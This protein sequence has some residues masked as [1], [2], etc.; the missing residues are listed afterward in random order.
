[1]SKYT[2]LKSFPTGTECRIVANIGSALRHEGLEAEVLEGES[3]M[4][5]LSI[6]ASIAFT[7]VLIIHSPLAYAVLYVSWAR[8]LGKRVVGLVWDHYPVT[9]SGQ[10]YDKSLRRRAADWLENLSI[11][12]CTHLIVP[13]RDFQSAARLER[14][15]FVPFWL[16]VQRPDDVF[17]TGSLTTDARIRI[18][19]AGQVNETR[20]LSEAFAELELQFGDRFELVIASADPVPPELQGM[21]NVHHLGFLTAEALK[22][23]LIRCHAGLVALSPRFDGPGLPSKTWEYLGAG[24]RCVFVGK[25]LPHYSEALVS[26]G[27]GVVLSPET[28]GKIDAQDLVANRDDESQKAR[29]FSAYFELDGARLAAHLK[30][31]LNP[32]RDK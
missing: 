24:L 22:A 16:P 3:S 5:R 25:P 30:R 10:R 17:E 29:A 12:L 31:G 18:I 23:E 14:A 8:L 15:A 27:A 32:G 20:G 4:A 1:M 11:S 6:F 13:S 7:D 2:I 19:F 9:L 26:S 21:A 28:R